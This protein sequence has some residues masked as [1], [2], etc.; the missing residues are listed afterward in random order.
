[1]L[2]KNSIKKNGLR[3]LM[4]KSKMVHSAGWKQLAE[5]YNAAVKE[6]RI[7]PV[8]KI[9]DETGLINMLLEK[10]EKAYEWNAFPYFESGQ[11]QWVGDESLKIGKKLIYED[12]E[13]FHE[14][15][16]KVYKGVH[17][18]IKSVNHQFGYGSFYKTLTGLTKGSP[19]NVAPNWLNENR[20]NVFGVNKSIQKEYQKSLTNANTIF[21]E[22]T[23][24]ELKKFEENMNN[25]VS[26]A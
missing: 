26:I 1:M 16:E 3:Q 11:V 14:E 12:R 4:M 10:R 2:L 15:E 8:D 6:N 17:Y 5:K 18:Y 23:K 22:R 13:Y 24:K 7:E 19:E 25:L 21:D 9:A 20:E